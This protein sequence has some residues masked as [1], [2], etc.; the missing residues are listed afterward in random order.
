MAKKQQ[1]P[2]K[3][4]PAAIPARPQPVQQKV[5]SEGGDNS[6]MKKY[7]V[8]LML[9]GIALV[10][11]VFFRGSLENKFTNWDD[12]GYV[13]TNPLIK[14]SSFEGLKKI[15]DI[16]NPVMGNYHPLTIATYWYEYSKHALEPEIYHVHSLMFHILCTFAVFGFVRVLTRSSTA[17]FVAGLLFA[18]HPMRVE[19][20]TWIA[21]RKDLMYGM[22]YMLACVTHI[23]YIR[24][25]AGKK[26][27]WFI[28]TIVLFALSLLCKS[29]G[30]TLPVVLL[31]IDY[32]ENRKLDLKLLLE[33]IPLFGLSVLFGLLSIYAQKDVGALGTLDVSFTVLERL[34]LGCYALCMYLWKLVVPTNLS[35]FYPYPMK[36][37]GSLP[38]LYYVF[39]V[40]VAGMLFAVW[41]FG[42]KNRLLILG[43]SFFVL[44]LLLL[45]QFI[46]VGGCIMSDRYTYIPY[47]GL[48]L[49]IGS[50]VAKLYEEKKP[51][52]NVAMGVV[53]VASL[54]FGYLTNERNKEW[55]D[56]ISLWNS[57]IERHPESPIPYFYMGQDYYTRFESALTAADRQRNGDSAYYF[58]VKS[59]ERKPDY[60]S[61]LICIGEYQRSTGKIDEAKA[62]YLKALSIKNDLESAYL[63]LGV[64]YSIKQQYDSAG[65]A[66]RRALALKNYFPEGHSNYANFLDITGKT[67]SSLI[68]Y[69]K[70]ISENPDAYIPYM[71]RGRIYIRL[72]KNDLALQDYIRASVLKPENGEPHYMQAQCYAKLGKK[73]EA[74]REVE[75]AKRLGYA[76]IDAAF[77]QSLK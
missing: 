24:N 28:A 45:L 70:A 56:S 35:N 61:P 13:L 55:Y 15:F 57:A 22:F 8:P 6:F 73:A 37:G 49:L 60:T 31:F 7:A 74:V 75:E 26:M 10:T 48:F 44:N 71:N 36:V 16:A 72:G 51:M 11:Y 20:V 30:V 18:I 62:T 3:A 63:G 34:A 40:L 64:V 53:L 59:V 17:A 33:K 21:G 27:M 9:A 39:P 12:L 46:P 29:V 54:V 4:R 43:L 25:Q 23:Y 66:F 1:I 42:R 69:A 68:E 58:F 47:V 50:L 14:D 19:S 67:D 41:K 38:A 76:Q 5:A 77:Y 32:Y 2:Q 52:A 65:P